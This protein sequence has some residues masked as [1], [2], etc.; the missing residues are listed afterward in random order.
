ME[1][2][3]PA[4][5]PPGV[6]VVSVRPKP[7]SILQDDSRWPDWLRF[8]LI[9]PVDQSRGKLF[10]GRVFLL[11]L[12]F[13][14]T[15]FTFLNGSQAG[16]VHFLH[17]I[18]LPI[19]E[20]GHLVFGIFGNDLLTS[21]GGSL[22]QLIMPFVCTLTL[23]IKTRDLFGAAVALWWTME[24]FVDMAPYIGDARAGVL[25]LIGGNTGQTAPYGFH[26]WQFILGETGLLHFDTFI[27]GFSQYL[28]IL[29][30]LFSSLWGAWILNY[31]WKNH[32]AEFDKIY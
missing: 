14:F 2:N 25:P 7:K 22:F 4:K 10:W 5:K 27:S 17:N 12:M 24:N 20:T 32:K 13:L 26:D 28:G 3:K 11:G 8:L 29:G 30:M 21:A 31:T 15:F 19:H 16:I 23:L 18:N 9:P 1:Q 6:W